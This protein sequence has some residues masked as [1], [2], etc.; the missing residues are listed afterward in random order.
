MY[1]RV[2]AKYRPSRLL[3]HLASYDPLECD[4][5]SGVPL[6]R[7]N[8]KVFNGRFIPQLRLMILF[9]NNIILNIT[10]TCAVLIFIRPQISSRLIK[11]R[12]EFVVCVIASRRAVD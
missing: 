12:V 10:I 3:T 8:K 9:D 11:G 7:L 4:A 5:T 2:K 1:L 6:P